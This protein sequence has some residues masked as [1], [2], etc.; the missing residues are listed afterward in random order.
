MGRAR[1]VIARVRSGLAGRLPARLRARARRR[2]G[3]RIPVGAVR[4]GDLARTA[5]ISSR[6]GFDRGTPVD[7]RYIEAFLDRH[8]A[9]VRGRVLE[10]AADTYA[11]RFGSNLD[12][13]DILSAW[14]GASGATIVADLADAPQIPDATFDCTIITQTLQYVGDIRAAVRTLNRILRPGGVALVSVPGISR[15]DRGRWPDLWHLTPASAERLFGEAFAGGDVEVEARGNVLTA[16]A[17]LHGLAAE[18]LPPGAFAIDD[19]IFPVSVL[20]RAR[21][22]S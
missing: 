13:V 6:W 22:P 4:L 21:K 3:G 8:R 9:D 16:T 20:V 2:S 12:R 1:I 19:P 14:T 15:L 5:P 7:R 10:V 17:F 11:S 18:E